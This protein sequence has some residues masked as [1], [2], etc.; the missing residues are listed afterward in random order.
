MYSP[1][2]QQELANICVWHDLD[3][4]KAN[5]YADGL[6]MAFNLT[7][8][9]ALS[10]IRWDLSINDFAILRRLGFAR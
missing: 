8:E 6:M 5:T 7:Y 3:L 9:D 2:L 10:E 4:T 1:A